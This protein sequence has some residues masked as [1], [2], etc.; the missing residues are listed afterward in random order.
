MARKENLCHQYIGYSLWLAARDL[1]YT[2]SYRWNSTYHSLL[3]HHR[4]MSKHSYHGATSRSARKETLCRQYIG[5][6]LRLAARDLL[7]TPS[8]RWNSTYHRTTSKRSYHVATSHS[9]TVKDRSD[10]TTSKRKAAMWDFWRFCFVS[11]DRIWCVH[12]SVL[13]AM[14]GLGKPGNRWKGPR[15]VAKH[16]WR[17]LRCH[18]RTSHSCQWQAVSRYSI[19]ERIIYLK[20][21][22]AQC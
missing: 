7:Y 19:K 13:T 4:T 16:V 6:S 8:H 15:P 18:P 11:F 3:L 20:T 17:R 9:F 5:Y 2:P 21:Y 1:L 22:N 14:A 10:D 12:W